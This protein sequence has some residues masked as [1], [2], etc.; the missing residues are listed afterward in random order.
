MPN[1]TS[2]FA[3]ECASVYRRDGEQDAIVP[4]YLFSKREIFADNIQRS[5]STGVLVTEVAISAS[6]VNLYMVTIESPAAATAGCRVNLMGTAGT[7]TIVAMA[8]AESF[9]VGQAATKVVR[10]F[11]G[12]DSRSLWAALSINASLVNAGTTIGPA[13]GDAPTVTILFG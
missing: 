1:I 5:V 4:R 3:E 8:V 9:R 10:Y 12:N 13:A 2:L 11:P 7:T 6:A